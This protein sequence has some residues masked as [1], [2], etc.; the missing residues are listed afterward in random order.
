MRRVLLSISSALLVLAA[1]GSLPSAQPAD[2]QPEIKLQDVQKQLADLEKKQATLQEIQKQLA[3]LQKK[4]ATLRMQEE[5]LKKELDEQA[6]AR[7]KDKEKTY[8]IKVDIKGRLRREVIN[9]IQ[10]KK[11]VEL[12]KITAK[13]ITLPLD[14]GTNKEFLDTA[15]ELAGKTVMITGAL[16]PA[17]SFGGLPPYSTGTISRPPGV[18]HYMPPYMEPPTLVVETIKSDEK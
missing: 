6:R 10:P 18:V 8:Y 3:D 11:T 13:N 5:K 9:Y 12:W 16:R 14:F 2:D 1:G 4:I 17:T 7:E 15:K